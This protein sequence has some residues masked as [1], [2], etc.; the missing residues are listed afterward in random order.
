[1]WLL[2]A[3]AAALRVFGFKRCYRWIQ[4]TA[5]SASASVSPEA[6]VRV[7]R[8]A[9][10]HGIY[11]GNCLS[12]SLVLYQLLRRGRI[13]ASLRIGVRRDGP[14]IEAHAWIEYEGL[15]LND[16]ADVVARFSS[17]QPLT[18]LSVRTFV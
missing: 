12:Q 14:Q 7:V 3:I 1:M 8:L 18:D 10:R 2:P 15:P 9:A 4:A 11:S 5:P 6:L 16:T 13:D 17:F